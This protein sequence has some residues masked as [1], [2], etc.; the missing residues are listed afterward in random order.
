MGWRYEPLIDGIIRKYVKTTGDTMTGTLEIDVATTTKNALILK[1]TDDNTTKSIFE[2][3]SSTGAVKAYITAVG[4]VVAQSSVSDATL[5]TNLIVNGTFASDLSSWTVSGTGTGWTWD[6][7]GKAKHTAGNTETL[8]Q[9]ISVTNSTY[10]Q[11]VFR[12][13][14]GT[15]GTFTIKLGTVTQNTNFKYNDESWTT[16]QAS[17]KGALILRA[18]TT[19]SVAFTITPTADFDG[20]FDDITVQAITASPNDA[21]YLKD[22][23][24][25]IGHSIRSGGS[26]L[27]TVIGQ[28]SLPF[29]NSAGGTTGTN[30]A[31]GYLTMSVAG[32]AWYN[33]A[34]GRSALRLTTGG[35]GNL[36][37]GRSSLYQGLNVVDNMAFGREAGTYLTNGYGNVYIGAFAGHGGSNFNAD[38]SVCIGNRAGY[39]ARGSNNF[40]LGGYAGQNQGTNSNIFLFDNRA[41]TTAVEELR[42]GIISGKTAPRPYGQKL[43]FNSQVEVKG[44]LFADGFVGEGAEISNLNVPYPTVSISETAPVNPIAGSI[45]CQLY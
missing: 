20:L 38:N 25:G 4:Q 1:S 33:V 13:T 3:R 14:G 39:T 6:A 18:N 12:V 5:D 26:G 19:A 2:T 10:Y 9:A 15:G 23:G 29:P 43:Q 28:S 32:A 8:S 22:S 36:C 21:L 30:V 40:F 34:I 41:R 27:N 24:G 37:I 35:V 31:I 16:F 44:K 7:S 45:W 11:I 42:Q 17:G